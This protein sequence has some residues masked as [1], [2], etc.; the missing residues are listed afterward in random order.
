MGRSELR[1]I[2]VSGQVGWTLFYYDVLAVFDF[3]D[4]DS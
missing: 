1:P 3:Q 4:I 2:L